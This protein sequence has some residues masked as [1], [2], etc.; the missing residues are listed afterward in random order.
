MDFYSSTKLV[1]NAICLLRDLKYI[2]HN[3]FL[4]L[5]QIDHDILMDRLANIARNNDIFACSVFYDLNW[6]HI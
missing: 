6:L 4:F 3:S 2:I 1:A 5:T